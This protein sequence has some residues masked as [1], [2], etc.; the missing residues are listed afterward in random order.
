MIVS[1]EWY[2]TVKNSGLFDKEL[3]EG[4]VTWWTKF[5]DRIRLYAPEFSSNKSMVEFQQYFC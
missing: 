2:I 5:N 1:Y 4:V 3:F